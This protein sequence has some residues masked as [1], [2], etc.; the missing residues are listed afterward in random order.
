MRLTIAHSKIKRRNLVFINNDT[1]QREI[2][3]EWPIRQ[4]LSR[5]NIT[6]SQS[7]VSKHTDPISGKV[8]TT[9]KELRT[10]SANDAA[11]PASAWDTFN[12]HS[13]VAEIE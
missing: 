9:S 6:N 3:S 13:T 8:P 7:Y 12:A 5:A 11:P 10:N 1:C 4:P 2:L